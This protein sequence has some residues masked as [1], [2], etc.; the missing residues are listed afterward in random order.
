MGLVGN[1]PDDLCGMIDMKWKDD[2]KP[3]L[4]NFLSKPIVKNKQGYEIDVN[5]IRYPKTTVIP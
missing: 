2:C 4:F 1:A 5:E 3:L